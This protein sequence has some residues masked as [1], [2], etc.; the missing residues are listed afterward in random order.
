[1]RILI[2]GA[3]GPL[4]R[5]LKKMFRMY[6]LEIIQTGRNVPNGEKG[7]FLDIQDSVNINA[8]LD[9]HKP[10][11]I[12]NL[13]AMTDVDMCEKHPLLAREIN[14][15]GVINICDNFQGKILHLSTDYVFNGVN[16]PYKENDKVDPISIYGETKLASEHI[17]MDHSSDNLIIRG[18][19][20]YDYTLYTNASFLNWVLNSLKNNQAIKVVDDQL[21]NP[22]WTQSMA[23][24]LYLSIEKNISG[25]Y[26]WGDAD[27]V[28]RYDFAKIIAETF[29][30]DYSLIKPISTKELSQNAARPLKSGL[31]S[32]KISS[33]LNVIPPSIEDCLSKISIN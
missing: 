3:Y 17:I 20:L 5:S 31:K 14:I 24:I 28:S 27:F 6:G 25:I 32:D 21:N 2:T 15:G 19:V 11:I 8:V 7:V 33:V 16:G 10:D 26:H 1:M 13:A 12:I 23:D 18:N 9:L 4:G 22:T 30:Y 29:N